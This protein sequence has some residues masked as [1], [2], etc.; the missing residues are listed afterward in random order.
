MGILAITVG[1]V[2]TAAHDLGGGNVGPLKLSLV[3]VAVNGFQLITW[4]RDVNKSCPTF[5]DTGRLASRAWAAMMNGGQVAMVATAQGCFEGVIFAFA[6]LWTPL[7]AAANALSTPEGQIA[8]EPPWGM[9]FAQQ[10]SCVMIGSVIFKLVTALYPWATADKMCLWAC[11]GGAVCF[12]G[13]SFGLSLTR[14]QVCL[15][16]FEGCVGVYLNGMGA[17][18]SKYVPQ[19][20]S[21]ECVA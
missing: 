5:G 2:V 12:W 1:P 3:I 17:M 13:L 20:V 19:E 15:L 10:L 9:V 14:T 6:L 11:A 7:L 4:R 8:R 18:R 21:V 16:G